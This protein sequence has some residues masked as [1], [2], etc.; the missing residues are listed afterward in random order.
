ME[1]RKSGLSAAPDH[2]VS[3]RQKTEA[4]KTA[5]QNTSKE[6]HCQREHQPKKTIAAKKVVGMDACRP[7][8]IIICIVHCPTL[9]A[10]KNVAPSL[11]IA[12][13]WPQDGSTLPTMAPRWLELPQ[14]KP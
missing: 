6:K 5:E 3:R 10:A 11:N 7:S 9:A 8:G 12:Q 14:R 13:T 2:F 4:E 1:E